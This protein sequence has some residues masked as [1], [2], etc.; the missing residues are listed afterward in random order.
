MKNMDMWN[1]LYYI[2]KEQMQNNPKAEQIVV[3]RTDK[4]WVYSFE[5]RVLSHGSEDEDKL[6]QDLIENGDTNVRYIVCMW[7]EALAL[8]VPSYH[9]RKRLLEISEKN[10]EAEILLQ[11]EALMVKTLKETMPE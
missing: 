2:A 7:K 6:I 4:P 1:K 5:N 9:F 8:D 11:G 10:A 3:L